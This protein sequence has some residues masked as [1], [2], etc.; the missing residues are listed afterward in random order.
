MTPRASSAAQ[1]HTRDHLAAVMFCIRFPLSLRSV[2]AL[3]H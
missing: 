1:D 3:L 2:E